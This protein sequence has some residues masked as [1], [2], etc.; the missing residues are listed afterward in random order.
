MP[1]GSPPPDARF[2]GCGLARFCVGACG[3]IG[4]EVVV[5]EVMLALQQA[6]KVRG[7]LPGAQSGPFLYADP[8]FQKEGQIR[9]YD[10]PNRGCSLLD[11]I[12]SI[13]SKRLG[14]IEPHVP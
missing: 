2:S 9:A 5:G 6:L 8:V 12:E 10:I 13:N 3:N 1:F 4:Q 14:L 11:A 7:E